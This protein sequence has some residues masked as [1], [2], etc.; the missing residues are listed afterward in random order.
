[1]ISKLQIYF[2]NFNFEYVKEIGLSIVHNQAK[3]L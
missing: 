3:S 2:N 1:M